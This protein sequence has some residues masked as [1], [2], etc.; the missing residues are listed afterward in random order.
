[1]F[2]HPPFASDSLVFMCSAY[3]PIMKAMWE[4]CQSVTSTVGSLLF[5]QATYYDMI[6]KDYILSSKDYVLPLL[7]WILPNDDD[8]KNTV[9]SPS[10]YD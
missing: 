10:H 1:M 5:P 8:G 7:T 4:L 9:S 3:L 6:C 2:S